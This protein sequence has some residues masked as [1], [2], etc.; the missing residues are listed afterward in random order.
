MYATRTMVTPPS[1]R[2][3]SS[4]EQVVAVDIG[5][6]SIRAGLVDV[7]GEPR[8]TAASSDVGLL[9]RSESGPTSECHWMSCARS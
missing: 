5:G 8:A 4:T 3:A 9:S 7:A 1:S 2:N 6:T